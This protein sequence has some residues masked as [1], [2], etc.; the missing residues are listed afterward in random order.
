M[1]FIWPDEER[2]DLVHVTDRW[3]D[4]PKNAEEI[5]AVSATDAA[6]A[7]DRKHL[8]EHDIN[9]RAGPLRRG[10]CHRRLKATR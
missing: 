3:R 5:R 9:G 7:F 1:F 2:D 10:R 6:I 8:P 4:A